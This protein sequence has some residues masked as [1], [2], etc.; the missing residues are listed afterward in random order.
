MAFPISGVTDAGRAA[1]QSALDNG[2]TLTFTSMKTGNGI[3]SDG[4]DISGRT[5]LKSLKNTYAIGSREDDADGV[6]LGAVFVNYDGSQTIVSTSYNINEVGLFCTVNNVEYLYALA[7]VPDD[8]G[9][10]IPAYNGDNLTQ[11]V[12]EWYAAITNGVEID[13]IMTGAFALAEDLTSEVTARQQADFE[14]INDLTNKTTTIATVDGNKVITEND[15]T[16]NVTTV[17]TIVNTSDTVKTITAV[18]TPVAGL[19]KWTK[20]TVI[21][22]TDAGKTI[23]QSVVRSLKS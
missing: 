1:M 15:S 3:Y 23:N 18:I 14:A 12:Q 5:A 8:G 16:N 11:I 2:Y 6:T 19:Y 4:E 13:V 10:E 17:T 20:T 9:Q 7:A 21:T 22:T